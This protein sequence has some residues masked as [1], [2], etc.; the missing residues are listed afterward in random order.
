MAV[1]ERLVKAIGTRAPKTIP[2]P[3]APA[4][5][6]TCLII[7]LPASMCGATKISTCPATGESICLICAAC[8]DMALSKA[9]GPSSTPPLICPRS[10]ILQSAA[11]SSV[12]GML[13]FTVSTAANMATLGSS[14]PMTCAKSIAF[15]TM[16]AFSDSVGA[17]LSAASVMYKGLGYIG[18]WHLKTCDIRRPVRNPGCMTTAWIN[19]SVCK[20]PFIRASN[21]LSA[22]ICAAISAAAWLC[23]TSITLATLISILNCAAN[24]RNFFSGAIKT[25]LINPAWCAS[26]APCKDS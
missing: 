25:A 9:K 8:A 17:I 13:G 16:S 24:A 11:A 6:S 5:I 26:I 14:N 19:S 15:C 18:T 1:S 4:N 7:I 22:A 2:A 20:L 23:G 10:A 12:D 21:F 3:D